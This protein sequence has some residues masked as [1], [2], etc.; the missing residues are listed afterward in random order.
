MSD[1]PTIVVTSDLHLGITNEAR[2]RQLAEYIETEQPDLT[3]LA[4]DIGEGLQNVRACLSLFSRLPGTVAVL[5]GNHDV[6]ARGHH[7]QDLWERHL[8]E[9]VR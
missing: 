3:V 2:I 6:W 5:A 1:M 4:G 7:S 9:A 8:P